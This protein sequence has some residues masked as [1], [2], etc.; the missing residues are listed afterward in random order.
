[1]F[2]STMLAVSPTFA[3]VSIVSVMLT[4]VGLGQGAVLNEVLTV[5]E[6]PIVEQA[7]LHQNVSFYGGPHL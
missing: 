3:R 7:P 1:M 4:S 6:F 5:F 2:F